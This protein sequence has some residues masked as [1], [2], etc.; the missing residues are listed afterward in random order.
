M[1]LVRDPQ[2][3][4]ADQITESGARRVAI[5]VTSKATADQELAIYKEMAHPNVVELR[6]A[7]HDAGHDAAIV[8]E[9]AVRNMCMFGPNNR[10]HN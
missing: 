7:F 6:D 3:W 5:K 10:V 8:T 2:V 9:L 1:C 4:S